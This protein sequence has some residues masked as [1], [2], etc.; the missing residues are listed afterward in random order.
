MTLAE[1]IYQKSLD[2]PE[3]K[4]R[5]VIEFIESLVNETSRPGLQSR[6]LAELEERRREAWEFLDSI[7]I[8]YGGKPMTD[9]EEA[10]ARR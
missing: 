1:V 9:R 5:E 4:A 10:N 8:D 6:S 7:K 2:L 3:D